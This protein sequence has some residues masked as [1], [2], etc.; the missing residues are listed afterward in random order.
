MTTPR[1]LNEIFF[2]AT[3]RFLDAPVVMRAK[4]G[5]AWVDLSYREL[6]DRVQSLSFGLRELGVQRGDRVGIL[7][8]NSPEW[9]TTDYACLAAGCADVPIY[10]TLPANQ[11][12]YILRDSGAVA[13]CVSNAGQLEKVL[14]VRA[15]L[16]A[17][18]HVIAFD[19]ALAGDGVLSLESVMATGRTAAAKYPGWREEA[20]HATPDDLATLI[21]TSGTTGDPKGVMLT[22]G[23][24]TSNVV[25]ALSIIHIDDTDE[26]LSFLPLSHI[27]ERMVG[28]YVMMWAGTTINYAQGIDT[29]P[30][31]MIDRRPTVMASVPR[32]Y[33]KIYAKV[34][35]GV[36]AGP[37]LRQ[38]IFFWAK[39]TAERWAELHIA[40]RPIP[41]GLA[42]QKRLADKLVFS[43]LQARTGGRVRLFASGGAPLSADIAR[44]F[45]AAGLPVLEGYGLTETSPIIAVN[46]FENI[47]LGTVGKPI[48][49]VEVRIAADG[50]I[51]TRGPH[52]MKGY[53]NKPE[54]TAEAIDA[55]GWFHTGDIGLIDADGFLKITDRKKDI[56]VTAGGKNIAP[57]PIENRTKTN[58]FILN[59]VMLGDKRKFP[60][61]LVVPNYDKVREW[62]AATGMPGGTDAELASRHGVERKIE[63][64]I[65][66]MLKDLAQFEVPKRI[67]LLTADFTIESGELTPTLK[68]KRRVVEQ[69]YKDRIDALYALPGGD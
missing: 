17:L 65:K 38:R 5:G 40:K 27:F 32:L 16:P 29:V 25:A 54:A 10:P 68:V 63:D 49:G 62:L 60:I 19:P 56:I 53:Y 12:A 35:E 34:L 9:A 59:A 13:V 23:N 6:L 50:E 21:Y 57:Q 31:D 1:T 69:R 33:E 11:A 47:R 36:M 45:Y 44:F 46:T 67:L 15:D 41:G 2:L 43:K 28:H 42:F 48:P 8:E 61:M 55:D 3:D 22:H 20:L 51:L 52:V 7:A 64:E 37:P 14:A 58:P 39:R 30:A 18:R 24:I 26:C 4:R 66:G